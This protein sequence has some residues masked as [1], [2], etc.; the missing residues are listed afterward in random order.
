MVLVLPQVLEPNQAT[1]GYHFPGMEKTW[2]KLEMNP[3]LAPHMKPVKLCLSK[4][5][6]TRDTGIQLLHIGVHS[7]TVVVQVALYLK[8][9]SILTWT[10]QPDPHVDFVE[11]RATVSK[12]FK[13][14]LMIIYFRLLFFVGSKLV[15]PR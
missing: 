7:V 10:L 6:Q 14:M 8:F 3:P 13:M 4:G 2:C 9:F 11:T 1:N 15:A 12:M 5:K